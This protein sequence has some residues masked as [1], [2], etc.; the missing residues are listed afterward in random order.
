MSSPAQ[1]KRVADK[2]VRLTDDAR[3]ALH[4][5]SYV[6]TGAARRKVNLSDALIAA[7]ALAVAD[8]AATVAKLPETDAA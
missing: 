7:C 5:L 1:P 4:D 6:L 3:N 2:P 8:P